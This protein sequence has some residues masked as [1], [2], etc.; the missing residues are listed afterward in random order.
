MQIMR[1]TY[2]KRSICKK[3]QES[4]KSSSFCSTIVIISS[5]NYLLLTCST[6]PSDDWLHDCSTMGLWILTST[7]QHEDA[8]T[9]HDSKLK[10]AWCDAKSW[11]FINMINW[12][13]TLVLSLLASSSRT[14]DPASRGLQSDSTEQTMSEQQLWLKSTIVYIDRKSCSAYST[15]I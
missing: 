13:L 3:M 10:D 5:L 1:L 7:K 14:C 11:L 2:S 6:Q 4:Q 9:K 15:L 12:S 8:W